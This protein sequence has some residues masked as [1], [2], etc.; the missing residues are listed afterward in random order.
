MDGA[1]NDGMTGPVTPANRAAMGC[2]FG[3]HESFSI[4]YELTAHWSVM[5]TAEHYS[6]AHLCLQNHGVS[7]FGARIGYSF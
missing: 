7:N 1:W 6:N 5:A 2:H 3:F 4:G